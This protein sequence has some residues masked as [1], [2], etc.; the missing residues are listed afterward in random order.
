[1]HFVGL[2]YK[3]NKCKLWTIFVFEFYVKISNF[4][5]VRLEFYFEIVCRNCYSQTC[6]ISSLRNEE[7]TT[8]DNQHKIV[9]SSFLYDTKL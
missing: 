8:V 2:Y 4:D 6:Y 3:C 5:I 1:M 7:S 9:N